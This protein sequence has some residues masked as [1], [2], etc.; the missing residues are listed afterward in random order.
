LPVFL[1]AGG[2]SAGQMLRITQELRHFESIFLESMSGQR[3]RARVFDL[4]QELPFAGHPLIGAAA[5]LH[6]ASGH[7]DAR[8]WQF[9]L[10][11]KSV[12]ITT[13]RSDRGFFGLLDVRCMAETAMTPSSSESSR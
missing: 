8:T 5:V 2:L 12:S 7:Q 3:V 11:S 4:S 6:H 9:E 10:P 1:D 13:E